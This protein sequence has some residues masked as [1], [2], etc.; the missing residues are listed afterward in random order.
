ML[1]SVRVTRYFLRFFYDKEFV[2]KR[3]N[4]YFEK[5]LRIYLDIFM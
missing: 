4:Q 5:L 1:K 3:K 2:F